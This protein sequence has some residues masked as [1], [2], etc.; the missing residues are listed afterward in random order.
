[1]LARELISLHDSPREVPAFSKRYPGLSAEAGYEAARAL[2]QHRLGRGWR[3]VGRKIGFTNRTLWPRYGVYEPMWGMVYDRTLIRAD[4]NRARVSLEGLVNPRLEPEVCFGLR[5][6][7][8]AKNLVDCI[9]W[10]AHSIE[11]VQCHHPD[12]KLAIAD[13]TANNGL[14]GRLIVGDALPL[15]ADAKVSLPALEVA[16]YRDDQLIDRGVGANVLGSPLAALAHLVELLAKQ[17]AAPPLAPGE[18][19]TTGV[20]TDAHPVGPGQHWSTRLSGIALAG[21]SIEFM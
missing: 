19:V 18:I 16:L 6:A 13:C 5:A 1:M 8:D 17:P 20:I 7:P 3:P 4:G 21:L 15:P 14:H 10:M 2:H 12:W 9:A 11:I